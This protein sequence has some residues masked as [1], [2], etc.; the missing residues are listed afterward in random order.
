M[1]GIRRYHGCAIDVF[2]GD[3]ATFVCDGLIH[4]V[5]QTIP[6][7]ET[8]QKYYSL[9]TD[10]H[11]LKDALLAPLQSDVRHLA[12]GP[13]LTDAKKAAEVM[14]T[15]FKTFLEGRKAGQKPQRLTCVVSDAD[16]YQIFQKAL[17]STFLEI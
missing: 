6:H 2:Q 15:T 17:F 7:S 1:L 9:T 3:L 8:A 14:L 11:S 16:S 12:F 13:L 5:S 10:E 4:A